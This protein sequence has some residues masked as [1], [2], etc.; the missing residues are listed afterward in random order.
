MTLALAPRAAV[1]A[2]VVAMAACGGGGGQGA[3]AVVQPP[4]VTLSL[5]PTTIV[6]GDAA[7]L[8]WSSTE[9]SS[10]TASGGWSGTEVNSGTTIVTPAA[11]GPTSYTLQCANADGGYGGGNATIKSTTLTVTA[12]PQFSNTALVSDSGV[13]SR[14]KDAHLINPWG[15]ALGSGTPLWIA[16]N[17]TGTATVYDG[18]GIAQPHAAPLVVNFP[19]GT[20]SA[21]FGPTGIVYNP[22]TTDFVVTSGNRSATAVFIVAGESGRI[23]AWSSAVDPVNG[24]TMYA[25]SGGA[26]YKGLALAQQGTA[27]Y[28]YATDFRNAKI[29]VFDARFAKQPTSATAFAFI[30]STL[31]AG[32][33]P[34]GIQ[35]V[36]DG[37]GGSTRLYVSYAQQALPDKHDH[38]SGAGLG[39]VDVYDTNGVLARHLIPAGGALN[40]PWGM[41]VAP[42]DFGTIGGD[43][44]IGNVGDGKINVFD[45][46]SGRLIGP[47]S[48]AVPGLWGIA[49]GNDAHNQPHNTL[50]YGVGSNA[51]AN[52]MVGRIDVG[53]TAPVLGAPPMVALIAPTGTVHG[54]A[55]LTATA[56]DP[57]GIVS[58]QF[59]VNGLTLGALTSAPYVIPWDTTTVQDGTVLLNAK[60]TDPDGNVAVSEPLT[61]TVANDVPAAT[62]TQIQSLV[63]TPICSACHNGSNPSSGPLPGS[64]NLTAGRSF[65]NLVDV[66]S[67]EQPA[68]L[69]VK[70]G[71]PS[72]SYIIQKLEGAAGIGGQRM[73]LGGPYLDQTTIDQIKSW[74]AGGAP[75]N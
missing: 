5:E 18:N 43:V 55:A 30:D 74:I 10:C 42:G 44:L 58:V 22:S 36:N 31:P 32:Y 8:T 34:F 14:A 69:R 64:Q 15:L 67:Q 19:T 46:I 2:A 7:T 41:A 62:L 35:A 39:I 24:V 45:P 61:V 54:V 56:A 73:P 28:L 71:D 68:V 1:M 40:A 72:D 13:G 6:L 49:F 65:A 63:F 11:V 23:G 37:P 70:P 57:L 48:I 52:G 9:G 4:S 29:D 59:Y 75:N 17:R 66:A 51:G 53:A 3:A 26:V 21:T 27:H 50:F 47:L 33:A 12:A 16:N 25:D 60:A 38:A 20:A